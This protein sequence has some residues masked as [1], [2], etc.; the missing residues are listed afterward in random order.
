MIYPKNFE[1]KIGFDVVRHEI[2]RHCVSPLGVTYAERMQFSSQFDE[3]SRLLA[4]TNEFLG[5]L[6]SRR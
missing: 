6:Q 2:S 1:Q 4:Q 5:I 3:V